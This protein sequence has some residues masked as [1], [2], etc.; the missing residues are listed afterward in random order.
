M[1][2]ICD[3]DEGFDRLEA[4]E[5]GYCYKCK[6]NSECFYKKKST[7]DM[8]KAMGNPLKLKRRIR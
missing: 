3:Y 1:D 4:Y 8:F 7:Q 6:C 2:N 5:I